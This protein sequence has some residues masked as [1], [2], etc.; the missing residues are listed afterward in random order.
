MIKAIYILPRRL[1]KSHADFRL[2]ST[3]SI[4]SLIRRHDFYPKRQQRRK[5]SFVPRRS[6]CI[7][8]KLVLCKNL[9]G[10]RV[11]PSIHVWIWRLNQ[12]YVYTK[13][14]TLKDSFAD[15]FLR[16]PPCPNNNEK[17]SPRWTNP[18][19]EATFQDSWSMEVQSGAFIGWTHS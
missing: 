8:D 18:H 15:L 5:A 14:C 6:E 1:A 2:F 17:P 3:P 4:R 19:C 7:G 16:I 12:V 10:Y 13:S 9:F 11:H